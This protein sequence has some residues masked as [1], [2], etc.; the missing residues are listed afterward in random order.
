IWHY[1]PNGIF[2]TSSAFCFAQRRPLASHEAS[3]SPLV[4]SL[5]HSVWSLLVLPKLRFFLWRLLLRI[6]PTREG[7]IKHHVDMDPI[8]PVCLKAEEAVE[9]LLFT[10][11][12]AL[13][14]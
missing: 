14:L 1:S 9:H 3:A 4:C 13:R 2:S 7:L 6:L 12:L 11:P 10:C 8:C 5:W